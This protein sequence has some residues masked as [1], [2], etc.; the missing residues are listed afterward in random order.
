M[1]VFALD[2]QIIGLSPDGSLQDLSQWS[3]RLAVAL[4][5]QNDLTLT[6]AHW[7][8]I[9]VLRDYYRAYHISPNR[10]LLGRELRQ[11]LG[12]GK[13]TDEYLARLFP[14]GVMVQGLKIAGVPPSFLDLELDA[15]PV[16]GSPV[17]ATGSS[18]KTDI[19]DHFELEGQTYRITPSGNLVDLHRWNERV[20][21]YLADK[22]GITLTEDHWEVLTYLRQFYFTYGIAPMV[23][24]LMRHLTD[25]LGP[26]KGNRDHLYRLFPDGPSS[27]GSRIA[28]LPKPQG[29]VDD[30]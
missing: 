6:D 3:E 2:G 15:E 16:S 1:S 24:L 20:A 30:P 21:K 17:Q 5:K 11:R 12:A 22:E 13:A 27:Q 7:E 8:V 9:H 28:G 25:E 18:A 10:K 26:D 23:K 19:P 14:C 29:C 4:A